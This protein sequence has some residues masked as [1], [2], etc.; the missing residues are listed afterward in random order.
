MFPNNSLTNK[1]SN[2]CH[3]E[4]AAKS[5]DLFSSQMV[6]NIM[7]QLSEINTCSSSS[8]IKDNTTTKYILID[9]FN[10]F[11]KLYF[12]FMTFSGMLIMFL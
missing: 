8:N 2:K 7:D 10:I 6:M 12:I 1:T 9:Y 11:I 4:N 3:E 5:L